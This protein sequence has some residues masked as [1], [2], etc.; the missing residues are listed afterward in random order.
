MSQKS[1]TGFWH[2]PEGHN[3]ILLGPDTG[4]GIK[5]NQGEIQRE[6]E[7]KRARV[8]THTLLVFLIGGSV[9]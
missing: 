3:R 1:I 8:F 5:E 4:R 9:I 7:K 2:M 6:I